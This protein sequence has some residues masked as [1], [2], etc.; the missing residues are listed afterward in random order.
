MK[1]KV[2]DLRNHLFA[3]LERLGDESLEGDALVQ[4]VTRARAISEVAGRVIESAKAENDYLKIVGGER[5]GSG[6][7]PPPET[8]SFGA[9]Q[10]PSLEDRC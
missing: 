1:N 2:E 4:E 8:P 10:E 5:S 3:E 7:L 6:F 9:G